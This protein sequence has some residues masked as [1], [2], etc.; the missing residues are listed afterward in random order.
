[1]VTARSIR[2]GIAVKVVLTSVNSVASAAK[3]NC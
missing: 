2:V 1:V 3:V